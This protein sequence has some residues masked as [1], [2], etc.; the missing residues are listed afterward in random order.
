MPLLYVTSAFDEFVV[1]LA[2]QCETTWGLCA[3]LK[4]QMDVRTLSQTLHLVTI[5]PPHTA[6]RYCVVLEYQF[7]SRHFFT[8]GIKTHSLKNRT[9]AIELN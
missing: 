2:S 4:R 3:T 8:L 5:Q 1:A 7:W 9:T 6:R